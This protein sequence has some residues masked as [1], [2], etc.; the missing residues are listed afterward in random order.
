MASDEVV[1]ALPQPI[2][3]LRHVRSTLLLGSVASLKDAG[4]FDGYVAVA[5]GYAREAITS[6]VAGMWIPID[7]ALAHYRACDSLGI[8]A[9]SAAQLGHGTFTR[10]KGLLL[11]TAIGLAKGAG[12]N[13]WTLVPY[14]QRF[15]NRGYDG[16]GAHA[17]K[18]GPKD[19]HIGLVDCPLLESKYY[20]AAL[21]GLVAGVIELVCTKAYVHERPVAQPR[22]AILFRVQ[23]V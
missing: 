3:P 2:P 21:R 4:Y 8:S 5:S 9:E 13:P 1:L 14:F 20:R 15:W 12:V 23:W 16:G 11:G 18:K 17:I 6:S 22:S 19:L 10:T 7:V